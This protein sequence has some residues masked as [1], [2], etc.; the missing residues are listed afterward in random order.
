MITERRNSQSFGAGSFLFAVLLTLL[1]YFL[2]S[3]MVSRH[4][5]NGG[6]PDRPKALSILS[7]GWRS[8]VQENLDSPSFGP[9]QMSWSVL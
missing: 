1:F 3:A 9:H 5:F 4:F 6:A 8:A 7:T 2:V